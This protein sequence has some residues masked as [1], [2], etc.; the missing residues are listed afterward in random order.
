MS[1]SCCSGEADSS[2]SVRSPIV[3]VTVRG[4]APPPPRLS[5]PLTVVTTRLIAW[6]V[7]KYGVNMDEAANPDIASYGSFNAFFTRPLKIG[8]R[9]LANAMSAG[10][11]F[12]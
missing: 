2:A 7:A 6:F 1:R 11:S 8:A 4:V 5:H 10:S 3:T 9:P 12:T